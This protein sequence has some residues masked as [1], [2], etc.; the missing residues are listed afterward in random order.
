VRTIR[1][2]LWTLIILSVSLS[3]PFTAALAQ[4]DEAL[5]QYRQKVMTSQGT[6]MGAMNDILKNKLPFPNHISAHAQ[7]IQRMTALIPEAFKKEITAGKTDAKAEIWKEWDKYIA[8]SE[9][10]G[11][12]A[13][14]LAEVAQK[15]DMEAITAQVKKVGDA[16]GTC[17]KPYRKPK[18]ESYK[19]KS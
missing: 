14:K 7:D 19:S 1:R 2:N 16:C 9:A 5:T 4:D 8:A 15:N 18:E 10:L 13:A 17:H 12:E 3:V 6:S 11:Q